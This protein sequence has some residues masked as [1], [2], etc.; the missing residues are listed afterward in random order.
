MLLLNH[1]ILIPIILFII[2]IFSL[3]K[4]K[5]LIFILISLEILTNSVAFAII[6]VGHYWNQQ[7]S[8]II[9]LLIITVAATE[10]S[11]MLAIFLK[12]YQRYNTLD[13][14]KLSEIDK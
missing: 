14:C 7:D 2:G 13:I 8:Q 9:Y 1:G 10:V 11:I 5:N 4:H 6:L 12:I 3:L